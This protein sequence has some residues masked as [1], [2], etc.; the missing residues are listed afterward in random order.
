MNHPLRSHVV[1]LL[2]LVAWF[3][4]GGGSEV[5]AASAGGDTLDPWISPAALAAAP[6]GGTIYIAS[7]TSRQVLI[8]DTRQLKI[9]RTI[10]QPGTPSGLALT[11][12]ARQLLVVCS[13]P[14]SQLAIVDL[15]QGMTVRTVRLGHTSGAPVLAPDGRTAYVCNR[16]SDSVSVVDFVAGKELRRIEAG[17]EPIAAALTAD[18]RTLF[19]ANHLPVGRVDT[20]QVAAT[21][22]VID[23]ARSKIASQV[24][25]PNGA[26]LLRDIRISPDG[27]HAC[28]SHTLARFQLPT[29]QVER[30]W[31]NGNAITIIDVATRR[32]INT[33]LLD[34]AERGAANPW[35]IAWSADGR[36]LLVTHAGTRELSVID[37][38]GLLRKLTLTPSTLAG[39]ERPPGYVTTETASDVPADLTFLTGLRRV[40]ALPGEGPRPV[41][42]VGQFAYVGCYFS[43]SLARVDLTAPNVASVELLLHPKRAM[44]QLRRGEAYFND[45]TIC[46]QGWQSCASCHSSDARV[47]GLNWDLLNDGVGN[48]KNSK[49]LVHAHETAPAMSLGIRDS[50]EVAVRAGIQHILFTIQPEEVPLAMDDWIKSLTVEPSPFL[51]NGTL[52]ASAKR[53][54][55]IFN[56]PQTRCTQC[57]TPG[58]F[59]DRHDY[60]VGTA[61]ATDEPGS[62]FDTPTLLELW[63]TGPYLHDGSA[64]TLR[65]VILQNRQDLHGG[66]SHL[67]R[68]E[69]ND[70]VA[71]LQSL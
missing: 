61:A 37:F 70:L 52:S 17:R 68:R 19:V 6:D 16:F 1:Q 47:D 56:S 26:N 31:M 53:G 40:M 13:A 33:V 45:G 44:S 32:A 49:S 41:V 11:S 59:T 27:R 8:Y 20:G 35:G 67:S 15:S 42:A 43:E 46:L 38:P 36:T 21:I 65:D 5:T 71:F 23:L 18:G 7:P 51:V 54:Q 50:A 9:I 48:P 39:K 14:E 66:T 3:S 57:H 63:R 2:L 58:L 34:E 62:L 22:S 24:R 10:N 69:I 29:S 55:A 4:G 12:D 28:V 25:L 30:G 64:A 60:D